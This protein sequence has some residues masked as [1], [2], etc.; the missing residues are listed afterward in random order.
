M[1][2]L[3]RHSTKWTEKTQMQMRDLECMSIK[4]PPPPLS[5][6]T[7]KEVINDNEDEEHS[8]HSR[9][10]AAAAADRYGFHDHIVPL[11]MKMS[12]SGHLPSTTPSY[13]LKGSLANIHG[14]E[15]E[16]SSSTFLLP[17]LFSPRHPRFH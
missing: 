16:V 11:P 8:A 4:Y 1:D 2:E 7:R 3:G 12:V 6:I 17:C 14:N 9:S 5:P 13:G 15:Y 10:A